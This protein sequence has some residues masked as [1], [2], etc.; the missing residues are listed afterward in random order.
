MEKTK[1][2]FMEELK[3]K[4][5]ES[6]DYRAA[7]LAAAGDIIAGQQTDAEFKAYLASFNKAVELRRKKLFQ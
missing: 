5:D 2:E 6:K 3:A 7:L 4:A 1:E